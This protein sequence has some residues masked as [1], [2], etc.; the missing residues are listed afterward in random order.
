MDSRAPRG[1][2]FIVHL[3]APW[4]AGKTS[5]LNFLAAE[6]RKSDE[7]T[8]EKRSVVVEFNAWRH[9][10]IEPPWWWLMTALYSGAV[11]DLET[12]DRSR[13]IKLRL[14]EWYWRSKGGW[15]GYLALIAVAV[16]V[17][18]AWRDGWFGGTGNRDL[19]SPDT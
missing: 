6:L 12:F 10:R 17:G 8:G 13:A 16:I 5:V 15:P 7:A 3:H 18:L 2:A 11:R 9:Q 19:F 4:G 1:G 14:H